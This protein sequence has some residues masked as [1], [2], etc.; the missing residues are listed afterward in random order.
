MKNLTFAIVSFLLL[1]STELYSQTI[2]FDK[3]GLE[4]INVSIFYESLM[5][6]EVVK[7]VKDSAIKEF[8]QP[9][10]AKLKGVG[11]RNGTIE[12]K[13]FS[14]LL[15]SAP[16]FSRGF[17]GIAFRI[18]DS[19]SK[20]ECI[21]LRPTN[22]RADNQLRRNRSIQ[23]FSFPDFSFERLRKEAPGEYESY[24]DMG[25]IEW[26][27]L[28]IVVKD[29]QAKLFLN[30]NIQPSL[31]VNDLKLG[32]DTAGSIGLWVDVGTEGFF[33]DLKIETD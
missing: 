18:N 29:N 4:P 19:N 24:S 6:E 5:G 14:R 13:V 17:I 7:V 12:V 27:N 30:N 25:L 21:Y 8:D 28:K 3:K 10:F 1:G 2:K 33:T 9:T 32:N 22:G 20:F 11:F 31:I 15:E 16:E 23:Y 26:I